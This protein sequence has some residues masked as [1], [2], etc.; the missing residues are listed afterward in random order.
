MCTAPGNIVARVDPKI[1]E[2]RPLDLP[3]QRPPAATR[4]PPLLPR[5]CT[6]LLLS[7]PIPRAAARPSIRRDPW[8]RAAPRGPSGSRRQRAETPGER[9]ADPGLRAAGAV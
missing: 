5:R 8:P 7:R 1:P 2:L 6:P 4:S 3:V 9:D